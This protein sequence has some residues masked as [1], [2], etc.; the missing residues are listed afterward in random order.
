MHPST[1]ISARD[2][3]QVTFD[4]ISCAPHQ[5]DQD[6][7]LPP[8]R[9]SPPRSAVCT[10]LTIARLRH[11]TYCCSSTC[12]AKLTQNETNRNACERAIRDTPNLTPNQ[13]RAYC[14]MN[15][16]VQH[17]KQDA[18]INSARRSV[19]LSCR[20]RRLVVVLVR[21]GGVILCIQGRKP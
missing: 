13:K 12:E 16:T 5:T 17:D 3:P 11:N 14:R 8:P 7:L 15:P 9:P 6:P 1:L 19:L 20:H 18:P 10:R 2:T 4:T 21:L